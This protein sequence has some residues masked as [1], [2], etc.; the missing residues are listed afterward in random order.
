MNTK[1]Y[2]SQYHKNNYPLNK[3]KIKKERKLY[4]KNNKKRLNEI[5]KNYYK[6]HKKILLKKQFFSTIKRIYNLTQEQYNKLLKE[7]N[8]KC[9]ICGKKETRKT[10]S[11]KICKIHIDHDHKTKKTRGVLCSNCNIG[12]GNLKH[13]IKILK[14]AI[15]YLR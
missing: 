4:Y 3:E 8:Y 10:P 5:S 14:K 11:G 2:N 1:E 15:Q 6:I 13:D 12:I 9:N 7:S